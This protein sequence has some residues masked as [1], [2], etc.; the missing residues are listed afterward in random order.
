LQERNEARG[1]EIFELGSIDKL[2][3]VVTMRAKPELGTSRW[4]KPGSAVLLEAAGIRSLRS[5]MWGTRRKSVWAVAV[6]TLVTIGV[7]QAAFASREPRYQNHPFS[8]W[9]DRLPGYHDGEGWGSTV[10]D[11]IYADVQGDESA[12]RARITEVDRKSR[13]AVEMVGTNG[14]EVLLIR[15]RSRETPVKRFLHK[16]RNRF[17]ILGSARV[18]CAEERRGQAIEA[19]Y[20]L[21]NR[22]RAAI[23]NLLRMTQDAD[24]LTRSAARFALDGVAGTEARELKENY[25]RIHAF[26]SV[27]GLGR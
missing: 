14:L 17:D 2:V 18:L 7:W 13:T 19:F 21:G 8:Y 24:P 23:P 5:V 3:E 11:F 15:L 16:W 9:L 20:V 22:A 6:L 4:G 26:E 25:D 12:V 27:D 10:P 1:C